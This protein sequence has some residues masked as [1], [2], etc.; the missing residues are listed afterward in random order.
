[1][2]C[3]NFVYLWHGIT[4]VHRVCDLAALIPPLTFNYDRN[5]L[6][7]FFFLFV[8]S[9]SFVLCYVEEFLSQCTLSEGQKWEVTFF[10]SSYFVDLF[11]FLIFFFLFWICLVTTSCPSPVFFTSR[12]PCTILYASD[13]TARNVKFHVCIYWKKK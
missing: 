4:W 12:F 1:M 9:S 6:R 8:L 3:C 10:F 5:S 7:L 2:F 11:V 13:T